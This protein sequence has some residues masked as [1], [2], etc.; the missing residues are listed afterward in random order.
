MIYKCNLSLKSACSRQMVSTP[1]MHSDKDRKTLLLQVSDT[2][3]V[4]IV[5]LW[6]EL[7]K[8][9]HCGYHL[10]MENLY[11]TYQLITLWLDCVMY[12]NGWFL[13]LIS[14]CGTL[15]SFNSIRKKTT[16][17]VWKRI[18]HS[19]PLLCKVYLPITESSVE[20]E[21]Y[22]SCKISWVL[23]IWTNIHRNLAM[24]RRQGTCLFL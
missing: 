17:P 18:P 13:H 7:Y 4:G 12:P 10:A 15:S 6:L 14:S 19:T 21:H 20:L 8:V 2:D 16:L 9:I 23:L 11:A 22:A 24:W 3:V 1:T 5:M